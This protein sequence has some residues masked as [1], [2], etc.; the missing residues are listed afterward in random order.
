LSHASARES[1]HAGPA[2][3]T[4]AGAGRAALALVLIA[5]AVL[6]ATA[7][8][9]ATGGR[10]VGRLQQRAETV[11]EPA[12]EI[13][14]RLAALHARE[15]VALQTFLLTGSPS[16]RLRY[17]EALTRSQA[18]EDSL[19]TLAESLGTQVEE[20][21]FFMGDAAFR[22]RS[23]AR[24][25][26]AEEVSREAFVAD[27]ADQR[28]L[29]S[30]LQNETLGLEAAIA[31]QASAVRD[32]I[33]AEQGRQRT[34]TLVLS[35][36]ALL[37]ALGLGAVAL[38]L[39][40]LARDMARRR[41]DAARARAETSAVL[42]ATADGVLGLDRS[43][44]C[45]F[46]NRAAAGLLGVDP[47]GSLGREA[48][49][50]IRGEGV[51]VVLSVLGSG[52]PAV[53]PHEVVV[54][55]RNGGTFPARL[56]SH[57]VPGGGS[58]LA[59]VITI[60]DMTR[61]RRAADELRRAV[62]ARERVLAVVSHDLRNPLGTVQAASELLI[63]LELPPH[64]VEEQ[65]R[66]IHRSAERMAGLIRD[67]LDVSVMES[68]GF[69]VR[70]GTVHL[71]DLLSDLVGESQGL[72]RDRGAPLEIE[73]AGE[74]RVLSFPGDADRLLQA[75]LNLVG[76][77]FKFSPPG[78]RVRVGASV[79]S[80]E[81]QRSLRVSVDDQGPGVP[82]ALR[83][84]LFEPFRQGEVGDAR[85]AGL[86]LAIVR[87]IVAAH[88]GSVG[89][90]DAPGGGARFVVSLPLGPMPPDPVANPGAG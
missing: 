77:A 12:S 45:T 68:G 2:P 61:E 43:G 19:G 79:D 36:L 16:D 83:D 73:V 8:V 80:E 89:V 53:G 39:Q 27:L 55:D 1:D 21:F 65:L 20:A 47:R 75:L 4:G 82:E 44:R 62:S 30:A 70:R 76:N 11:I 13:G 71:E 37:A 84:T 41:R 9:G 67:L 24:P 5:V 25:V 57:A 42:D 66:I 88:G 64:K 49:H 17:G 33:A 78:S 3:S 14:T 63:E 58:S 31:A 18:T 59:R 38:H 7:V 86:G 29:F 54:Q 51:G 28:S 26:L 69:S 22:W 32:L 40:S 35:G 50:L 34:A 87:G 48:S 81:G 60:A 46:I 85:G 56:T 10:A 72:A 74:A 6:G 90:A 15:M 23:Q 52:E